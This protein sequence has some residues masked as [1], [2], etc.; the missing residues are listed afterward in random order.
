M[1]WAGLVHGYSR[2]TLHQ[3]EQDGLYGPSQSYD[4]IQIVFRGHS[5]QIVFRDQK[6][7]KGQTW[8]KKNFIWIINVKLI[9]ENSCQPHSLEEQ[10]VPVF[11]SLVRAFVLQSRIRPQK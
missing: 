3:I 10:P 4:S 1:Q 9:L 11:F 7:L 8:I 5:M 6:G 2:L